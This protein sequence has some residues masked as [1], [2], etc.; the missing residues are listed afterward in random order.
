[1]RSH[2]P[3][4]EFKVIIIRMLTKVGRR[5]EKY[6]KNF[7]RVRKY[8]TNESELKN[9]ITQMKHT[10]EGIY[11]KLL[12]DD[13]EEH[14]SIPES[15]IMET[16]PLSENFQIV[17]TKSYSILILQAFS[18]I[19]GRWMNKYKKRKKEGHY[20]RYLRV[21][22]VSPAMKFFSS[23]VMQYT[24]TRGFKLCAV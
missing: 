20:S 1:M 23:W 15:K 14:I 19:P 13:P 11:S 8:K 16:T 4:K 10:L 17:G 12:I 22:K 9:T 5:K 2:L 3:R 6:N 18:T 24:W 7:S 21:I